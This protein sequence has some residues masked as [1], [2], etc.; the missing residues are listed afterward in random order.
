[1]YHHTLTHRSCDAQNSK[2]PSEILIPWIHTLH[3]FF[4]SVDGTCE[5]NGCPSPDRLYYMA[6]VKGFADVIEVS[7]RSILSQSKGKL[8]WVGLS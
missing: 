3:N 1:M 4:L 6:K 5:Y 2:M 8:Y 7:S